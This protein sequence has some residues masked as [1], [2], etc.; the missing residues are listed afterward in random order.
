MSVIDAHPAL[1][2]STCGQPTR[3]LYT[4][5]DLPFAP[6]SDQWYECEEGHATKKSTP[7]R[8]R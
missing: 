7:V 4:A 3:H 1:R 2:C 8:S 6:D 5:D